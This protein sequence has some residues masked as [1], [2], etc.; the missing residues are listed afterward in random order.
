MIYNIYAMRKYFL[1]LILLGLFTVNSA[2]ADYWYNHLRD[3][4]TNNRSVILEINIRTFN[5]K[6]KNNNGIIDKE[7][8]EESGN[9]VNAIARLDELKSNYINAVH[10]M[11]ITPVGKLKA[12]GTAGSL[13]SIKSFS[14]LNPQL[15]AP[16]NKLSVYDE[17]K[18]FIT[19]CHK[20]NIA[21]IVD[22]PSCGSYD[23]FLSNPD[24]FVL[25][26]NGA[27]VVPV[28]WTDTR[29]FK[30]YNDKGDLNDVLLDQYIKFIDLMQ[31]LGVDGIRADVATS[32]PAEFWEQLI[33]HARSNDP[34]FLFLAE[35]S[36]KWTDPISPHSTFTSYSKLLD[37][38]F[39]G[40]YGSFFDYK[41][42]SASEFTKYLK[43]NQ[44]FLKS[45]SN[46]QKAVIGSFATHD[47]VSPLLVAD[48]N[49]VKQLFWL[50]ATLPLNSYFVDGIQSGDDYL[51]PYANK[52]SQKT[53]T[54]DDFYY[55][56]RG[57]FDIFNYSRR[58]GAKNIGLY[59]D[60]NEANRFKVFLDEN[61]PKR[62]FHI[63]NTNSSKTFAY[64]LNDEKHT[65]LVVVNKDLK[66]SQDIKIRAK[67]LTRDVLAYPIVSENVP[68]IYKGLLTT[69]LNP[70]E[71]QVYLFESAI[72]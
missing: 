11:P 34:Q 69:K 49:Y 20:R 27:P 46:G 55:V 59:M 25:D 5:A 61:I 68:L 13:Y 38:G 12:L 35:A 45:Q 47:E 31:G 72:F 2:Y 19:E 15:D 29:L 30:V 21:V 37:I 10:I 40:F 62:D 32:K 56:H 3:D 24:L 43:E 14:E 64:A 23:L 51:Y 1:S 33:R 44:K 26:K 9:F 66:I 65:I 7:L 16:N 54:D 8:G 67:N 6:D 39:D 28:D 17:A 52:K 53:Y 50:N 22:L 18:Q 42:M 4:F 36:E 41:N 57:K 60:Y 63:V 70:G 71:V 58:P 48:S